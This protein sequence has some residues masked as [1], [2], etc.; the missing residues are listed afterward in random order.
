MKPD[1][2]RTGY[3]GEELAV[4]HLL[5][6]GYVILSRNWWSKAVK[7]ELD[8]V[9]RKNE[10]V[11]FFEVKTSQTSSFGPSISWVTPAK[12]KRITRAAEDY[13]AT[14]ELTGCSF[15]FDVIGI[16]TLN[17]ATFL[18]HIEAAFTASGDQ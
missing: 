12:V 17:A 16:E 3:L 6:K 9:A 7:Y 2:R 13:I 4:K 15:R 18:N 14:H 10:T 8:I 11:I 1:T 5:K